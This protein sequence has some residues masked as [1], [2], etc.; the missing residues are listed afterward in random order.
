MTVAV[1]WVPVPFAVTSSQHVGSLG[2]PAAEI[3]VPYRLQKYPVALAEFSLSGHC[4]I[5]GFSWAQ[6]AVFDYGPFPDSLSFPV[7]VRPEVTEGL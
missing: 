2:T 4:G 1:F 6:E 3:F 7:L 5:H